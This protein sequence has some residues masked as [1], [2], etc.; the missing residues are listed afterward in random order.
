MSFRLILENHTVEVKAPEVHTWGRHVETKLWTSNISSDQNQAT[1]FFLTAPPLH[2]PSVHTTAPVTHLDV[3]ST[4]KQHQLKG[5][6]NQSVTGEHIGITIERS[7][8][9]A[10][11]C[12]T[13]LIFSPATVRCWPL[14]HHRNLQ[15]A[16][17]RRKSESISLQWEIWCLWAQNWTQQ[18]VQLPCTAAQIPDGLFCCI[19]PQSE[20]LFPQ[21]RLALFR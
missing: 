2:C 9:D 15:L 7:S 20:G 18:P 11:I 3:L 1:L 4:L 5:R 16:V 8:E 19:D 12:Y 6:M 21:S 10:N 14:P 13:F 17:N